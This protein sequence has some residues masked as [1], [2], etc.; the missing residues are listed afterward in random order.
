MREAPPDVVDGQTLK[1]L[2]ERFFT[3]WFE[4]LAK[5]CEQFAKDWRSGGLHE[6]IIVTRELDSTFHRKETMEE[7][8][9][10]K[11]G[12]IEFG[13]HRLQVR[14]DEFVS[15][16][17]RGGSL[18][19]YASGLEPMKIR[20]RWGPDKEVEDTFLVYSAANTRLWFRVSKTPCATGG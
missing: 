9:R 15:A 5:D 1:P 20:N 8:L 14:G 4:Q 11:L 17:Y 6:R 19:V 2:A 18:V 7:A 16:M 13:W 12:K 10:R 3:A